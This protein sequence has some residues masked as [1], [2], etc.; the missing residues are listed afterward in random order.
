MKKIFL[1]LLVPVIILIVLGTIACLNAR[2]DSNELTVATNAEF[3]PFERYENG[4]FVGFD[5]DLVRE[6]AN[7]MGKKLVIENMEFDATLVAVST[8]NVDVAISGLTMNEKRKR[9]VDFTDPY[10]SIGQILLVRA[11]DNVFTGKTATELAEQLRGKTIGACSGFVGQTY[12]EGDADWGYPGVK[13]AKLKLYDNVA[14]GVLDLQNGKLD[15][16]ILDDAVARKVAT[17]EVNKKSVKVIDI[18]LTT[19]SYA[20][21]V[22]KGNTRLLE[23]LNSALDRLAKNG[24]LDELKTKWGLK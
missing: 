16:F 14:A 4:E 7:I 9:S 6:I 24:K 10:Y 11:G 13:G 3:P 1:F 8:G 19:E 22:Q 21:A 17:S 5:M 12:V 2:K 23:K 20:I 15:V 18:P